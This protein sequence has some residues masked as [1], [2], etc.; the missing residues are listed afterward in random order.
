M[1]EI[2]KSIFTFPSKEEYERKI[3]ERQE[4]HLKNIEKYSLIPCIHDG[5]TEC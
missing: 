2:N 3:K 5:C 4:K 1:I